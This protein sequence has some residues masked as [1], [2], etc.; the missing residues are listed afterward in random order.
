[1]Q[2]YYGHLVPIQI[3]FKGVCYLTKPPIGFYLWPSTKASKFIP[4]LL[5]KK[6]SSNHSIS[7]MLLG[8]LLEATIGVLWLHIIACKL[9]PL[10]S[11][12][13]AL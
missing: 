9:L 2:L 11:F 4:Q 12:F 7:V 3:H 10:Y 1:L 6:I 5:Q 8:A 13:L